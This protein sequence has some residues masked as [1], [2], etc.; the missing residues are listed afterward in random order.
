MAAEKLIERLRRR[1]YDVIQTSP[2]AEK[3]DDQGSQSPNS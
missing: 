1:G 2:G 3:T